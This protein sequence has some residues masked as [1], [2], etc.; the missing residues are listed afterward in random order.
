MTGGICW[1][2]IFRTGTGFVRWR[3]ISSAHTLDHLDYYLE[4]FEANIIKAGGHVHYASNAEEANEIVVQIAKKTNSKLV[5]KSKSMV[6]EE[7]ELNHALIAAGIETVETD[8]GELIVQVSNDHPSQPGVSDRAHAGEADRGG[9][10][11]VF[12]C[13]VHG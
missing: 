3:G 10:C 8:L 9:V 2:P 6:S 7:T 5:V 11:E 13:A 12:Q 4:Q 1:R